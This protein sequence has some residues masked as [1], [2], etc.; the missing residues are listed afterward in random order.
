MQSTE[1][2][3]SAT[4]EMTFNKPSENDGLKIQMQINEFSDTFI[5]KKKK[6]FRIDSY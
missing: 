4:L 6:K 2:E 1:K 5:Y 3:L